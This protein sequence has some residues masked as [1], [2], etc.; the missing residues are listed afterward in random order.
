MNHSIFGDI[1]EIKFVAIRAFMI[2]SSEKVSM[3]FL[4]LVCPK[5]RLLTK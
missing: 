1:F 3:S 5:R 4:A 2:M